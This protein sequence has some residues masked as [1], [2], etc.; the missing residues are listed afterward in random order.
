MCAPLLWEHVFACGGSL[1]PVAPEDL[2]PLQRTEC[3]AVAAV[4]RHGFCHSPAWTIGLR[5]EMLVPAS[6]AG[7]RGRK[8]RGPE[9]VCNTF[10][11]LVHGWAW[12]EI[13][14]K[15][16]WFVPTWRV[17]LVLAIGSLRGA[18]SRFEYQPRGGIR[19]KDS[20]NM[21]LEIIG[22][23]KGRFG[24]RVAPV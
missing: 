9:V 2:P 20:R 1:L 10:Q 17:G 24:F 4:T 14:W 16:C 11:I 15:G 5:P 12:P 23:R 3:G 13:P 21:I 22:L 19:R 8:D 18:A 7:T 6:D